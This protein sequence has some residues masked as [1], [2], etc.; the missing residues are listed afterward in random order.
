MEA[1]NKIRDE[2]S[3]NCIAAKI[4]SGEPAIRIA[5]AKNL[6]SLGTEY[7]KTYLFHRLTKETDD[8]V[9]AAIKEALGAIAASNAN[10]A[11]RKYEQEMRVENMSKKNK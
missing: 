6:G 3:I 4:D 11:N 8:D 2:D 9:K 5:A 1:L 10:N 7:A